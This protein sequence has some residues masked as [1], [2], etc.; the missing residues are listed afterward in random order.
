MLCRS[1]GI[2]LEK[3][4]TFCMHSDRV[5]SHCALDVHTNLI[6]VVGCRARTGRHRRGKKQL[7]SALNYGP[8]TCADIPWRHGACM[9]PLISFSQCDLFRVGHVMLFSLSGKRMPVRDYVL[10]G[11]R[12]IFA[13]CGVV[14]IAV[15]AWACG[16]SEIL[17]C[18]VHGNEERST[19]ISE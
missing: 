16:D 1:A 8:L 10:V 9:I 13:A 3:R 12:C 17:R 5:F 2:I 18:D 7:T 6:S 19:V 4:N 14:R 11:L 15:G